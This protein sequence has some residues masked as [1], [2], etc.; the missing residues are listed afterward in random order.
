VGRQAFIVVGSSSKS[1]KIEI[2]GLSNEKQVFSNTSQGKRE[3]RRGE[4]T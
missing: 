1:E 2:K 4:I 3:K